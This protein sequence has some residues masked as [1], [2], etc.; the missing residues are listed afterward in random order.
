MDVL[1]CVAELSDLDV[2]LLDFAITCID[3]LGDDLLFNLALKLSLVD[4]LFGSGFL[5]L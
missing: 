1:K 5:F 4:R 2:L 3:S